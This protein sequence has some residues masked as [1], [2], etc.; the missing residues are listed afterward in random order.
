MKTPCVSLRRRD[1]RGG[2]MI[3]DQLSGAR[4]QANGNREE[5]EEREGGRGVGVRACSLN[6]K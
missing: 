5:R 6:S 3:R 4:V 2:E 1:G